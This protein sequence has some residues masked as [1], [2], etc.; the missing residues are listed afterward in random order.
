MLDSHDLFPSNARR[1]TDS[2][3]ANSERGR[4][5]AKNG[6]VDERASTI[7]IILNGGV[8]RQRMLSNGNVQTVAVYFR[9]DVINL[10]LYASGKARDTDYL[11][12]LEGSVIGSVP[13]HVMAT[14]QSAAPAGRDGMSALMARELGIAHEHLISIGQRSSIQ[15]M[16]HFFCEAFLRSV[17]P[18]P[19]TDRRAFP[20]TQI[21]L[22]TVLGI[23]PVHVNRTLQELRRRKL[24]DVVDQH[25]VVHDQK[26]L[27]SLADF[28]DTY[29]AA[30]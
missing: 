5:Y 1:L 29:L 19:I 3:R 23:S 2:L 6:N 20:M 10:C 21:T 14:M 17:D 12:A 8:L 22:S 7:N 18:L 4:P 9:D 11:L 15:A 24:A 16:A 13:Y 30:I 25:L 27:A 26:G 28:D